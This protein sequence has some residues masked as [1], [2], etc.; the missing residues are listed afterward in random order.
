VTAASASQPVAERQAPPTEKRLVKRALSLGAAGA[1]D[2]GL[3]FLLPVVLTR[4]LDADAFGQYR[5]LWLAAGTVMAVVTLSVPGSLYYYLPRSGADDKRLYINQ[6][7]LFLALAGVLAAWAVSP[8]NPLLPEMMRGFPPNE[9]ILP[10][11]ILLWMASWLLDVLPAA[12][13]RVA[14]QARA[15]VALS[16]LR[17][18]ALS[19][20]AWVTGELGPVLLVLVA[21]VAIKVAV[22]LF[23][24]ARYHGLRGPLVRKSAFADQLHHAGL[25]SVASTLYMLQAQADQWIAATL[26][27]MAM[28]ASFSVAAVVAPLVN[29]CRQSMNYAFLP[30]MS[31]CHSDGDIPGMVELNR[32]ANVIVGTLI[33]PLLAF[34]FVFT[35]EI[36]TLVYTATYLDGVPVMRI[37]ILGLAAMAVET[38]TVTLQLRQG[39]HQVIMSAGLLMLSIP[40]S[41]LGALQFGL[42]GAALGSVTAI[43]FDRYFTLRMMAGKTDIPIRRLQDWRSLGLW[44]LFGSV[45]ALCAWGVVELCLPAA[46][47]LA[48]LALAGV[49]MGLVYGAL[50]IL[51]GIGRAQ[52]AAILTRKDSL[53]CD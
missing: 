41:W 13:E 52:L 32:R 40:V 35:E 28:F 23:Y 4:C 20:T 27:S 30:T 17:A 11:F 14:W 9:A 21:F 50:Q 24:I 39:R 33:Y 31:R 42:P 34:A 8:W 2:Y 18:I 1:I 45:A 49:C 44:V 7:L 47:A 26:F 22:L 53:I 43:Y 25:F 38:G 16:A 19:L 6:T 5:V 36:V 29:L 3:Q 37:Y 10:I 46:G 51:F 48:R 12:E 15:T